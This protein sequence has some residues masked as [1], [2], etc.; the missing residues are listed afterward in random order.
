MI[1]QVKTNNAQWPSIYRELPQTAQL[2]FTQLYNE[3]TV[4]HYFTTMLFTFPAL[5]GIFLK[6]QTADIVSYKPV[7][8][9]EHLVTDI[10][11][12]KTRVWRPKR[13]RKRLADS[14]ELPKCSQTSRAESAWRLNSDHWAPAGRGLHR[15]G[16]HCTVA[17]GAKRANRQWILDRHS[18]EWK[19]DYR[20]IMKLRNCWL[21]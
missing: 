5:P 15:E 14:H 8:L 2:G 12:T 21:S 1:Y 16:H 13:K 20:W 17:N 4:H 11:T 7:N 10:N 19:C 3:S 18:G 9:V 6:Q